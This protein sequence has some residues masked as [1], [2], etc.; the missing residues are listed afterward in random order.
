MLSKKVSCLAFLRSVKEADGHDIKAKFNL[1]AIKWTLISFLP[2]NSSSLIARPPF[3]PNS[4]RHHQHDEQEFYYFIFEPNLRFLLPSPHLSDNK[5]RIKK[6]NEKCCENR[7]FESR[8]LPNKPPHDMAHPLPKIPFW[9]AYG[10][11][12]WP[13]RDFGVVG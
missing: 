13:E 6:C 10:S 1:C 2:T 7:R 8:D 9:S 11:R 5:V 3:S 12:S 4:L